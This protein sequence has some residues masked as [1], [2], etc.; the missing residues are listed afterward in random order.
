MTYTNRQSAISKCVQI[1]K[2]KVTKLRDEHL[3]DR[4]NTAVT[5]QL[6]KAQTDLRLIESELTVEEIIK[7]RSMKVC[8]VLVGKQ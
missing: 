5:K 4:D 7:D 3:K 8:K 2:E 1:T 6:R